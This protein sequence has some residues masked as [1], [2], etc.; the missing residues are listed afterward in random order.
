LGI[1]EDQ[2][3]AP[4]GAI[5]F[6]E[7]APAPSIAAEGVVGR[8]SGHNRRP[9]QRFVE[10]QQQLAE[11]IVSYFTA[12]E[13]I[14]PNMYQEDVLLKEFSISFKATADPDTL[15][16]HKAMRAPDA[17][18]F[19]EAM[20]HEVSKHTKKGHWEVVPKSEVSSHSKILPAVWLIKRK[21]RIESRK[22]YKHKARLNL[23][24]TSRS[25]G[26]TTV[27]LTPLW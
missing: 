16:L 10:S 20:K 11:G 22:V 21:R 6:I 5:Q 2:V 9:K 19:K 7:H 23:G 14:D 15:Y 12:H 3:I 25:T 24:V 26:F 8:R 1:N 27:K 17:A 4:E 13:A 18:Q